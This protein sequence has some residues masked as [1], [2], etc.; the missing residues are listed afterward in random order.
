VRYSHQ[1]KLSD[2]HDV[3]HNFHLLAMLFLA[4]PM[5]AVDLDLGHISH[6]EIVSVKL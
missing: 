5:T 1:E 2:A 4:V 6:N 3:F